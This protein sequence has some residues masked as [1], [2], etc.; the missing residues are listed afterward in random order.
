MRLLL[1]VF[2]L[3][4]AALMPC[5]A[6]ASGSGSGP[7]GPTIPPDRAGELISNFD[8]LASKFD[9]KVCAE[10]H[11]DVYNQWAHSPKA[12]AFSTERV[13]QTWRTFIKQ[14]LDREKNPDWSGEYVTRMS[15]KS[16]CLWCH[17]PVIKYATDDLVA[18]IID[19]IIAAVDDPDKGKREAAKG[20][21]SKL[22]LDCYGCHNMFAVK[23][24]YWG[25]SSEVDAI[26][27]PT[28]KVDPANHGENVPNV[29][30]TIKSEY[31]TSVNYCAT[32]H[33]GCPDSVPFWQC[34]TLYTSYVEN[35]ALKGGKQRCQDCHMPKVDKDTWADHSFPGVHNKDFFGNALDIAIEAEASHFIN[36]YKNEL[37]PTLC[38]NVKI[39]SNSGHGLPNG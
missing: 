23:D 4:T 17:A 36:N 3:I 32:C 2:L 28:G 9:A 27:G 11:E 15:I 8:E 25:N 14:G 35:Y 38:L 18:E 5:A 30:K 34:K 20:K 24:G 31:L 22:N 6:V 16:H 26:Y 12:H 39:T 19:T 7:H 37:T 1:T 21:L 33:H 10:C 13:L 29:T